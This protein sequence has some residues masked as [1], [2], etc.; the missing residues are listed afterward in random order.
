[1]G[2]SFSSANQGTIAPQQVLV[3]PIIAKAEVTCEK[4]S[5]ERSLAVLTSDTL[6]G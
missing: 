3:K 6:A 1:M 5:R 4:P 2:I